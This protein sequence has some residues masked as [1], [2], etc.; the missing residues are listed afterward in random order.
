MVENLE[1]TSLKNVFAPPP[2]LP[3]KF[4]A[5]GLDCTSKKIFKTH[6]AKPFSYVIKKDL[7]L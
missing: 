3:S 5:V 1:V 7:G 6:L 2:E 4:C